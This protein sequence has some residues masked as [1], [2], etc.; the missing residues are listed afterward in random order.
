[1]KKVL[2]KKTRV[3]EGTLMAF[4]CNCM[5]EC[6]SYAYCSC[7]NTVLDSNDNASKMGKLVSTALSG[8][9]YLWG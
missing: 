8:S 3:Q 6:Q 9:N 5:S 7:T 1:M 2:G 4:A